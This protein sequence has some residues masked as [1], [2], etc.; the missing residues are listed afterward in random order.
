PLATSSDGGG[1]VRIPAS[2]CGL[3][4]Y[5]PTMG[6]IGRNVVPRWMSLST[7]GASGHSV[8]DVV[9]EASVTLGPAPGDILSLPDGAIAL[10]PVRPARVLAC[11]SFRADVDEVIEAA[12]REAIE[13]LAADGLP[14][15]W[16]ESPFDAANAIDWFTIASAD[17]AE[18]MLEHV[19][20]WPSF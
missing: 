9:L 10:D 11:R 15:E 17:L 8:A 1:S 19:E 14:V 16:V 4:G 20:H 7:Q 13:A 18:S 6:G 2:C 5:K 3:V 12:M